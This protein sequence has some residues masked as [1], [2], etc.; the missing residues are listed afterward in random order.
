MPCTVYDYATR[1]PKRISITVAQT[2]IERLEQRSYEEGRSTSNLAAYLL[3]SA[4]GGL[5]KP[6]TRI[7]KRWS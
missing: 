4:L 3:E 7:A 1:K 2:V 6:P 5:D